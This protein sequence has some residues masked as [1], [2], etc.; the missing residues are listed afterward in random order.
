MITFNKRLF[1]SLLSIISFILKFIFEF[2]FLLLK[3]SDLLNQQNGVS[4]NTF[5]VLNPS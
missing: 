2:K 1:N 5:F 3:I 4:L